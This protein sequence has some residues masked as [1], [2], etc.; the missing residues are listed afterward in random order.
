MRTQPVTVKIG[1]DSL[2]T[3]DVFVAR[4][5][6]DEAVEVFVYPANLGAPLIDEHP[7]KTMI[8]VSLPSSEFRVSSN[9]LIRVGKATLGRA[10]PLR[11]LGSGAPPEGL[12][13]EEL[14]SDEA[15]AGN[16]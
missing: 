8:V 5:A 15:A 14:D 11:R 13:L 4:S 16:E 2:I 1:R 6:D 12:D 3:K 7:S 9:E 10:L